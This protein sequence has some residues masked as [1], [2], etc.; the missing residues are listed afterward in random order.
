MHHVNENVGWAGQCRKLCLV[1]ALSLKAEADCGSQLHHW[2][3]TLPLYAESATPI[4]T[5]VA[6]AIAESGKSIPVFWTQHSLL[7]HLD[8]SWNL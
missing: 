2:V 8:L 4:Y 5:E 7:I 6:V 1:S 3:T